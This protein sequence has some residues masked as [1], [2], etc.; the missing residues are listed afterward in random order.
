MM[1]DLVY[2]I[3]ILNVTLTVRCLEMK[4]GCCFHASVFVDSVAIID[5]A[6][7]VFI[8]E[9]ILSGA[10][11]LRYYQSQHDEEESYVQF[12]KSGK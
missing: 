10:D 12:N 5:N 4:A 3:E 9:F 1:L 11:Q 7:C 8:D 2:N 6:Y